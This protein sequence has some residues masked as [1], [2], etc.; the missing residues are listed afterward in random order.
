MDY[1]SFTYGLFSLSTGDFTLSKYIDGIS[2][3]TR[4]GTI[5]ATHGGHEA[6]LEQV[7]A[8][9][10]SMDVDRTDIQLIDGDGIE[11]YTYHYTYHLPLAVLISY[12]PRYIQF[13]DWQRFV[14]VSARDVG[15]YEAAAVFPKNTGLVEVAL[16]NNGHVIRLGYACRN[17]DRNKEYIISFPN[18]PSNYTVVFTGT[19]GAQAVSTPGHQGLAPEL[20]TG[21]HTASLLYA[22]AGC[23]NRYLDV[24]ALH[25]HILEYTQDRR[26]IC[27]TC[28]RIFDA[29]Y[30]RLLHETKHKASSRRRIH[31]FKPCRRT[32]CNKHNPCERCLSDRVEQ[33]RGTAKI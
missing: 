16:R 30:H 31:A 12:L 24:S 3:I 29:E 32:K 22:C 23:G 9:L 6:V 17:P 2:Y 26:F 18:N 27:R 15:G 20:A 10:P 21:S 8:Y 13:Q 7:Q 4:Q 5:L 25:K 19:S 28:G 14:R 11:L 33:S 1:K